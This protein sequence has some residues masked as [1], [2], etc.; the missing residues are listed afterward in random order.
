VKG[1]WFCLCTRQILSELLLPEANFSI[2][3][4]DY[5]QQC[6][7][8]ATKCVLAVLLLQHFLASS[9]GEVSLP[10][11]MLVPVGVGYWQIVWACDE[12][13]PDLNWDS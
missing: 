11:S 3:N 4:E 6:K 10:W 7:N 8:E 13:G 5:I 12:A 9:P 1:W 2:N